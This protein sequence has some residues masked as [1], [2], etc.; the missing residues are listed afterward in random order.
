MR[1][2]SEHGLGFVLLYAVSLLTLTFP[3]FA[4]AVSFFCLCNPTWPARDSK[5]QPIKITQFFVT[6]TGYGKVKNEKAIFDTQ[7]NYERNALPNL[8]RWLTKSSRVINFR[9]CLMDY[10]AFLTRCER[11]GADIRQNRKRLACAADGTKLWLSP[12]AKPPRNPSW[13]SACVPG[14]EYAPWLA[15]QKSHCLFVHQDERKFKTS[16]R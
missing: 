14:F 13:A 2:N 5:L 16:F 8:W 10:D 12:S 11:W 6:G 3:S 4:D 15:C 9:C 1:R 7:E